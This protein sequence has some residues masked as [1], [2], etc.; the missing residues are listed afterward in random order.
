MKMKI[1]RDPF[2]RGSFERK[3][4]LGKGKAILSEKDR[5]KQNRNARKQSFLREQKRSGYDDS[6]FFIAP[7]ITA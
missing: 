3:N 7:Q 6:S 4:N 2:I 1:P 5:M